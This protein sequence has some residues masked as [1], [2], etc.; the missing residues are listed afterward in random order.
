MWSNKLQN[1]PVDYVTNN[2]TG[3]PFSVQAN[4]FTI[5][6]LPLES[7][8]RIKLISNLKCTL[9]IK[10]NNKH[11]LSVVYSFVIVIV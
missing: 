3:N 1:Q 6:L 2:W 4:A 11:C 9:Y 5:E 8:Y 10:I 7:K